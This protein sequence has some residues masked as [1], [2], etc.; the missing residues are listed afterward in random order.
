MSG[1]CARQSGHSHRLVRLAV[2]LLMC[3][4][5]CESHQ[6]R[7]HGHI[8]FGTGLQGYPRQASL[9]AILRVS[10]AQ[11]CTVRL[12]RCESPEQLRWHGF[13]YHRRSVR[14][15]RANRRALSRSCPD[16]VSETVGRLGSGVVRRGGIV[17]LVAD[18]SAVRTQRRVRVVR[19][20]CDTVAHGRRRGLSPG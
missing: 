16:P 20:A 7:H 8:L 14:R 18:S 6:N 3:P 2:I 13:G 4:L 12:R 9:A 5:W 17:R 15:T 10:S 1:S 19:R 11:P